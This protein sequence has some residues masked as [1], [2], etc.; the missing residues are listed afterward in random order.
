MSTREHVLDG[1]KFSTLSEAASEFTSALGF[2]APWT[3][4]LDALDDLLY[5]WTADSSNEATI[6]WRHSEASRRKL[7]Y[8]ETVRWYERH[9]P[10]C[11]VSALSCFEQR[12]A[13]A[14]E[15]KG[16]TI[17]DWL[18]EIIRNHGNIHL[19]LE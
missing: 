15:R 2:T 18:V 17:F 16:Q 13:A 12:L 11:D 9:L 14:Q 4:N 8:E 5:R 1:S 6:I 19:R 7:A 10:G 3:G